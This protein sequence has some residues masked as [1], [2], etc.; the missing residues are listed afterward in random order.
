MAVGTDGRLY[1]GSKEKMALAHHFKALLLGLSC[2]V[3]L[4]SC[5]A[6]PPQLPVKGQ[7]AGQ[8]I[9][10][11][12]D[13][14]VA[15]YYLEHYLARERVDPEL[16]TRLR[17]AERQIR[18]VR[19][20]GSILREISQ[21]FSPDLATL[22]FTHELLRRHENIEIYR[23]FRRETRRLV[24]KVNSDRPL[25]RAQDTDPLLLFAPGWL[26]ATMNSGGDFTRQ[27]EVLSKMG[28]STRLIKVDE[29]GSVE[30]NA[31]FIADEIQRF[32]RH[33]WDII[34]VSASKGGPEAAFALGHLLAPRETRA[35]KAWINVGGL[36]RGTPLADLALQW[37][38]SW[39]TQAYF[40]YNGWDLKGVAGLTQAQSARRL[41]QIS[42]PKHVLQ[43]NYIGAPLSGQ[44]LPGRTYENYRSMRELGP[45]DG[46][47]LLVDELA[48]GGIT[49][50]E[51]GLDH[52]FLD[53]LI[54]LK[55]AALARVVINRLK[56]EPA[57]M[58]RQSGQRC[59]VLLLNRQPRSCA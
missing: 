34:L 15:R 30:A 33:G 49:L 57:A 27:R 31:A 59:R 11:T 26:Y 28:F 29:N 16:H 22:L 25:P 55:T 38:M 5:A 44:V 7:L 20:T 52:Y 12:V 45:N 19:F 50:V 56:D 18:N 35:V 47:A 32:S 3:H 51:L 58:P 41:R 17:S 10:T 8:Q 39:L 6:P 36:L 21:Q 24:Q 48:L 2:A 40:S 9:R 54:D 14:E 23:A 43:I 13:S 42:I 46:L 1:I 4:G 53:P 37:P